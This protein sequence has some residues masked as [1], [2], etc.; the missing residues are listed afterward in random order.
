V[1]HF[2]LWA[3]PVAAAGA[4]L[5]LPDW[6][7]LVNLLTFVLCLVSICSALALF[8]LVYSGSGTSRGKWPRFIGVALLAVT[9]FCAA[10]AATVH[11]LDERLQR[12]V[13]ANWLS[14]DVAITVRVLSVRDELPQRQVLL[15]DTIEAPHG[16]APRRWRLNWYGMPFDVDGN[17]A[18]AAVGDVWQLTVR[19]S[20]PKP[21]RLHSGTID[22]VSAWRVARAAAIRRLAPDGDP[23]G[24]AV[25][26]SLGLRD[27]INERLQQL[28]IS[29]G[30]AHLLAISGLHIGLVSGASFMLLR[31]MWSY[32]PWLGRRCSRFAFA[33]IGAVAAAL[34]Y[35]A[36][37]GFSA[38]TLRAVGMCVVAYFVLWQQRS[39]SIWTPWL[40]TLSLLVITDITRLL[41][42]GMWLSFGTVWLILLTHRGRHSK[43]SFWRRAWVTHCQLGVCLL[44]LTAW[45][46]AQGSLIAPLANWIAVPA[47]S[48]VVVPLCLVVMVFVNSAPSVATFAL[49]WVNF[50][51]AWLQRWLALLIELP[52]SHSVITV[53]TTFVLITS[54][55]G[56]LCLCSPR[57]LA[58]R[59]FALP[60]CVPMLV[61]SMG[62]RSV[63]GTPS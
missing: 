43:L 58:L 30:T 27:G 1:N 48:L 33:A 29:T 10:A 5:C 40:M 22:S 6:P 8:T 51:M 44:P 37:A 3:L 24:I 61:W 49:E 45:F 62:G 9:V 11:Q 52:A 25:A 4:I 57:G 38:S 17:V 59:R 2:A 50:A 13:S 7:V 20:K 19:R 36:C 63:P 26:L 12:R 53:P 34:L 23:Y 41:S 15:V 28:L 31:L 16:L 55:L 42:P 54:V 60:L 32:W 46:F 35:A 39:V 56:A 47:V 21:Q 14:Q 18:L